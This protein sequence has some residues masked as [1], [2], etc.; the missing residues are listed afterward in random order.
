MGRAGR[1]ARGIMVLVSVLLVA[2]CGDSF[3]DAYCEANNH[4]NQQTVEHLTNVLEQKRNQPGLYLARALCHY[5]LGAY[6]QALQ[7]AS[8]VIR[9][10]PNKADAYLLRAKAGKMLGQIPQALQDY[11]AAIKFQPTAEAHYGRGLTYL[12]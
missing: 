12:R 7:D 1:I 6:A 3:N 9:R 2:A 11:S 8:E 10:L 4:R 5:F